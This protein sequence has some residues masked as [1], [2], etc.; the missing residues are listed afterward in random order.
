ML[1]QVPGMVLADDRPGASDANVFWASNLEEAGQVLHGYQSAWLSASLCKRTGGKHLEMRCLK[2]SQHWGVSL[3][4]NK[5]LAGAPPK[6][7]QTPGILR[8]HPAVL[9]AFALLISGADGPP[10]YPGIAGHE[11]DVPT[12]RREAEAVD[13]A[14]NEVQAGPDPRLI[15][16]RG[17]FL[18]CGVAAIL[19]AEL[20]EAARGEGQVR[21]R[22]SLLRASRSRQRTV[23]P[24]GFTRLT[25][26]R[27]D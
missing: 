18:R 21:S 27:I 19:G 11:P 13:R 3:H 8:M 26:R 22:W 14:I 15:H 4:T 17:Q 20:P 25:W 24:D 23:S 9:D 10:A 12:A 16:G 7:S 5:G 6:Q 2:P 1:K